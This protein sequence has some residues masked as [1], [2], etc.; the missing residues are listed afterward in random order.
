MRKLI[1]LLFLTLMFTFPASAQARA[2]IT[3]ENLKI[4]LWPDHDQPNVLVIYDF[5]LAAN[6]PLP[7][8]MH[9]QMPAKANLVAVAKNAEGG[10]L[11]VEHTL[12][13]D[14]RKV[15]FMVSDTASYHLEYYMPYQL[16][17][18]MR[19]FVFTWPGDYA[20]TSFSLV[21]Q[22]P[23]G[24]TA[25]S[26]DPGLQDIETDSN[27]FA[28]QST[29]S[30]KLTAEATY[31]IHVSYQNETDTLSASTLTVQ[32]SSSLTENVPGQVSLMNY[33]P[34]VLGLLAV[35]LIVGGLVWYWFSSRNNLVAVP[36]PR[37][38]RIRKKPAE[39]GGQDR[40]VYC[41]QCGKRAQPEDHFCRTCG[42]QLRHNE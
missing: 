7:T 41:H 14:G 4:Q 11:T 35:T 8:L 13:S 9:F 28:Y 31:Q 30:L 29:Q 34:L 18:T 2:T 16:D 32:P 3:L 20:V 17:G 19:K 25:L 38:K 10:L 21:L 23:S 1:V 33:V 24:A 26:T 5:L 12:S 39:A 22:K 15:S 36:Q 40:Q 27:G 37:S 6:T 42:A